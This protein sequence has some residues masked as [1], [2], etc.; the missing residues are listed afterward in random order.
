MFVCGTHLLVSTFLLK[1]LPLQLELT[2]GWYWVRASCDERLTQLAR[3][4][5]ICQGEA[6]EGQALSIWADAACA[7]RH[8]AVAPT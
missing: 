6:D 4:G 2:D 7:S 3:R 5:R 8:A 1:F